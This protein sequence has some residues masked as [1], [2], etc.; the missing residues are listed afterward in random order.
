MNKINTT[1]IKEILDMPE[2]NNPRFKDLLTS[3]IWNSNA[4]EVKKIISMSEWNDPKFKNLLR[5][6]ICNTNA[7]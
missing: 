3:T 2:W 4:D 1:K 7:L 5:S 6:T